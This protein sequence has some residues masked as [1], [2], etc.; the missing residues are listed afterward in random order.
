[1][2]YSLFFFIFIVRFHVNDTLMI[3][4][5]PARPAENS[6][7]MRRRPGGRR[8]K[9]M[10]IQQQPTDT[11]NADDADFLLLLQPKNFYCLIFIIKLKQINYFGY[12]LNPYF[13]GLFVT[14]PKKGGYNPPNRG[15]YNP[16]FFWGVI[17][18]LY[19]LNTR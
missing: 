8:A 6:L 5:R 17:T 7:M 9:I 10:N 16:P 13:L 18:P 15:G 2:D 1:M 4:R 19:F 3:C 11:D 12:T 14:P